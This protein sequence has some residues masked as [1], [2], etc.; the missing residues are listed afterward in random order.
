MKENYLITIDGVQ[1]NDTDED[2]LSLTTLGSFYRRKGDYFIVYRETQ[3]TGF[4]GDITTLKVEANNKVTMQ[5]K[6]KTN[7]E[8]TIERG[9]KH[10]CHYDTGHGNFVIG[11]LAK[12]IDNNLTENGGRLCLA[13][14]LDINSNAVSENELNITVRETENNA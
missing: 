5:R 11:I 9:Q 2:K 7:S 12:R 10:L 14:S 13:Y 3:A 8:L 1:R 6:G 4:D